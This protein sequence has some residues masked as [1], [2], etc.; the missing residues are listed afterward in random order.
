[1][2][3]MLI[4]ATQ[5][6]EL[7]VA[8]VDGQWLYDLDIENRTREQKKANIYKGKITRVEPSLEAAFVD[9]GADRH[10]FLPLKEI[11]REYFLKQPKDIEGR[12][13]IKD[14]V[15]EGMEVIVQVDKEERGNK[16]AALTTFISL[17]GR[18]LVLM[19][20]NPR[21][22]GISRRIEGDERS[23]LRDALSSVEVPSGMGIIVRTAG[24]GRS[25]EELQ[26]DLNYL[27]QLWDAIKK[28]ADDSKAPHFLFQESNVI[29]RAIRDYMRDD[30]GEVIVDENGAYQ[31][32]AEFARQVMPNYANKVK[33]YDDNIPLFNRYQIES[34]IETAFE[35]E[36]KLPSGGS[37][38]IDVTEALISIDINSSR[39]TKGGDIEETARTINLEAADEIARQL[40]LRDM[41]GLVVIDFIDMQNKSS[42]REVEKRMEKALGMDRA[43]V[44]VGRI[45]R[46]GLLEMSRQR[47]RPSLSE[48]THR[49]CP[50]CSGQGTIR[51]T[52]S[53]ALSIL[54]LVEE[55][56]KKERSAEI[57]A[58]TP[59]NVATYLLNEKRKAISN[60]E[61]RNNT[62]VVVVPNADLETPHFEVLR[63]RDDE[64]TLETSYKISGTIEES[65]EK[66]KEDEPQR[67]PAQP[68]V[69]QIAHTA[70]APT[71]VAK[72]SPKA[73]AKE[74]AKPGLFSRLVSAISALF[75]GEE[76]ETDKKHK[77]TRGRGKNYQQQRNRNQ[78]GGRGRGRGNRGGRRDDQRSDERKDDTRSKR[79]DKRRDDSEAKERRSESR[80]ANREGARDSARDSN[81][82]GQR[83][84]QRRSRRRRG[85]D[86]RNEPQTTAA[87][88]EST[89]LDNTAEA[90]ES[91]D[92]HQRPAR[93]P[94]NV[95]G[96]PQ[97]RRRGRRGGDRGEETTAAS[98]QQAKSE[99]SA[100]TEGE[101][102]AKAEQAAE[103]Q[104]RKP[105]AK[106]EDKPVTKV[107]PKAEQQQ[108]EKPTEQPESDAKS[109][110]KAKQPWADA[111][112]PSEVKAEATTEEAPKAKVES[113]SPVVEEA[114]QAAKP[115][116]TA[117]Q[118]EQ[119]AAKQPTT[120]TPVETK[121]EAPAETNVA[122]APEAEVKA[123]ETAETQKTHVEGDFL[124]EDQEEVAAKL[125]GDTE[126][127][128]ETAAV[129]DTSIEA[130]NEEAPQSEA[131]ASAPATK[132]TAP[133]TRTPG[134]AS[135]DPRINPKPLVDFKV[136][137]A[138]PEVGELR[139]LDTAQP[140]NIEHSPRPLQRPAN[141]PRT[142][143]SASVESNS[144]ST[145]VG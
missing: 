79:G 123:E 40:R 116:V 102:T 3:R 106:R 42:Q 117:E 57:R 98:E 37:I 65:V 104:Q 85:G 84:G 72:P 60:I 22:G 126:Q 133:K 4:N 19:P 119:E 125:A 32:A 124:A 96:R 36:V 121:A 80:D 1:M 120:E 118:G 114:T 107:E 41:G 138:R 35:R 26:W 71:P 69:Q 87:E 97:P 144:D 66:N 25:G 52:K 94:S 13:K 17:A 54:R 95:R 67:A 59:V 28:E 18:Y 131:E 78:R 44:Q 16:G 128:A 20:N 73:K 91:G 51:G 74:E 50:R 27:L 115:E 5:P 2:K 93:R 43:R 63:L 39:A 134:R 82:E 76:E 101:V 141:D 8:L 62:R 139:P 23:D 12:I 10:G 89:N 31:L 90:V 75:S 34:Q 108:A 47:L 68:A 142:K 29:I 140:A 112:V 46:F 9:Y 100:S 70:P 6:E 11:S 7:R 15:K 92:D 135:N 33:F 86:R 110:E 53:L 99:S 129:A 56:A 45:S 88:V 61:A 111:Q 55:E 132:A 14:V 130:S 127:S 113:E 105:R 58:I 136:V 109:Q 21:A 83:E 143:R 77:K 81:R 24:V 30:I 64:T 103:P 122:Q 38:V 137:T 145:E 48:T 49:V